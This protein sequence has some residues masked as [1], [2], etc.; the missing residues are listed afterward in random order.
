MRE[1]YKPYSL[2]GKKQMKTTTFS[3]ALLVA[4]T[5]IIGAAMPAMS[6]PVKSTKLNDRNA[7]FVGDPAGLDPKWA[8]QRP[9]VFTDLARDSP[10]PISPLADEMYG[11]IAYGASSGFP[12]G[13]CKWPLDD[14]GALESIKADTQN[15]MAGGTWTCDERWL[16]EQYSS[17]ML[18]EVDPET[19]DATSIG[20]GGTYLN[21]LGWD[22]VYNKL[23]GTDSSNNLYLV[24]SDTGDQE[25]IGNL[26]ITDT[27]ISLQVSLDGICTAYDVKYTGNAKLYTI[28]LENAEVIDTVDMGENLLYA[29][30]GA[31]DWETGILWLAGY[32]S[33]GFLAYWDE[34]AQEIVHI[35]NFY[36]GAEI[37][38]AMIQAVC[39]PPEHDISVKSIVS[40]GTG[41]ADD[42][43]PM[44]L[45][46]KNTGNHT[47]T[48]NAQMEVIKCEGGPLVMSE[49]FDGPTFPP[50]GWETDYWYLSNTNYAGGVAPEAAV[51][52]YDQYYDGVYYDNYIQTPQIDCTGLEKVNLKFLWASDIPSG[53]SASAFVK[54][55]RNSTSP[56]KDVTPWDNPITSSQDPEF[57]EIG[58]YGFGEPMGEEFQMRFEYIGYYYYFNYFYL[59]NVELE[60][61]GG[62]AEYADLVEYITLD[63]GEEYTVSF[64]TWTP[65]EWHNESSENTWEEYP[66]HGWVYLEGD[67][68]PRNDNKW[69]LIDLWYPWMHDIGL[70]S[71]DS[72]K[73]EEGRIIPAQTFQVQATM[74][75]TGQYPECCIPIEISIG[76]PVI[77]DT[78]FEE[79]DWPYDGYPS[80]SY[81]YWPGYASGWTDEHKELGSYLYG[82][83]YYTS[84]QTPAGD[85]PEA[86]LYYYYARANYYF[87]TIPID[88]SAYTGLKL[89]FMS[90]INHYS[91]TGL[92]TLQAGYSLDGEDWF[93][94]WSEE[95][96]SSQSYEVSVPIEGG[97]D[98]MYI[99]FWCLGDPYYFNY[100]YIDNVRLIAT[101]IIGEFEDNACQ[102]PDIQPGDTVTFDFDE[103][104][105]AYLEEEE[106]NPEVE[107]LA[108]AYITMEGDKNP[109]N[110]ILQ[111]GFS[112]AYWHDVG[113]DQVTSPGQGVGTGGALFDNGLPDGRNGCFYG[114]YSS[115]TTYAIDDFK[116]EN[117]WVVTGGQFNIA[118]NSGA[119][120]GNFDLVDI[121]FYQETDECDPSTTQY[122]FRSATSIN[123]WATGDI[124]FSRPEIVCEVEFDA[125]TL[126]PGEWWVGFVPRSLSGTDYCAWLTTEVKG[127]QVMLYS[128]YYGWSMWTQG[129]VAYGDNYDTCFQLK[130]F[131]VGPPEINTYIQPG[132]EDVSCLVK[133]YG[134]F[135]HLDLTCYADVWEYISDPLYGT[136]IFSA[137]IDDI[138]LDTPLGGT[139]ALNFGS[140]TFPDEGRYGLYLDLPPAT[141]PDDE[142]GNNFV[143]WGIGADDTP[144]DVITVELTPSSPDGENGWYVSD[145][146]VYAE[147]EDPLVEDVSSGVKEI[148]Y[149]INGDEHSISGSSG[150]FVITTDGE[151]IDVKVWAIDNVGNVGAKQT[152]TIDMDQ[153]A[154]LMSFVYEQTGGSAVIG[155]DI[156]CTCN[157]TDPE[158]MSDMNRVEFYLNDVL[159]DTVAG[160]GPTYQW[161]FKYHGVLNIH[162]TAIAFD[163]AGNSDELVIDEF[164]IVDMTPRTHTSNNTPRA[165][166]HPR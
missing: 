163:N 23:Y 134:T 141:A 64:D 9:T 142:E 44:E 110:D 85:P 140:C 4:A 50:E 117:E 56:W 30:D 104:T 126:P 69:I 13:P 70:Q 129:S 78:M 97:H 54:F 151:N 65:S 61:C 94:A 160:A 27:I 111:Q 15:W 138:D 128:D 17:G 153:K 107:Y 66:I 76:K 1:I 146:E 11:W 80:G 84:S 22:P 109:G 75:N 26:G 98:L 41:P 79:Y 38:A 121:I 16:V 131:G 125:V 42:N 51:Y 148:H 113:I 127:C 6:V 53:Y 24:D 21:G 39:I 166:P 102:G 43:M 34:D 58:C 105:P 95:P 118:W 161:T 19:G 73:D 37:A 3:V 71:I 108:Q 159:Q 14:P 132:S 99:G 82:W 31:Y 147:A 154:P 47:E 122:A 96:G 49:Y 89:E 116:N 88:A 93:A 155:A 123:D 149:S 90:Y 20:G 119:G 115:Y 91:G 2:K 143:R 139:E 28:D 48:F 59:D 164:E 81:I 162:V 33:T 29:Q 5:F 137:Q 35:D 112:L 77:L 12:N 18:F 100:W 83:R 156:L 45:L 114:Y 62:C 52:K 145:V 152:K 32:S 10:S 8:T 106:S 144:P 25:L 101:G 103:W 60:A 36:G 87:Y 68:N 46:V 130:G 40:P 165:H 92:Y 72:P 124:Y 120:V 55:R 7:E 157:A 74:K 150:T 57:Y 63:V 135:K 136:E 133:N 86:Y 158:A 67:Q